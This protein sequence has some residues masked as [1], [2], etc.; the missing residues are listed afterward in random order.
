L[1]K[2]CQVFFSLLEIFFS[3]VFLEELFIFT[4]TRST[5]DIFFLARRAEKF[6]EEKFLSNGVI[7]ISLFCSALSV[8]I[9]S[10]D[11]P[12]RDLIAAA[13]AGCCAV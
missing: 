13:I 12:L 6:Y 3:G 5:E 7:K 9:D 2:I 10:S 8:T 1:K 4:I 11:A